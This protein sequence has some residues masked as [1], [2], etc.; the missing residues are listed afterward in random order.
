MVLAACTSAYKAHLS[1][2][3][4]VVLAVLEGAA[5]AFI[6]SLGTCVTHY[7][8]GFGFLEEAIGTWGT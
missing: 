7:V 5:F 8:V 3:G 2:V 6:A 4:V 1:S